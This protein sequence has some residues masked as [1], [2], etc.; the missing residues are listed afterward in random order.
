MGHVCPVCKQRR[1]GGWADRCADCILAQ[2]SPFCDVLAGWCHEQ[3]TYK[4]D[5][6]APARAPCA[7]PPD[8]Y[9]QQQKRKRE[10]DELC[11]RVAQQGL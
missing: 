4:R 11:N 5:P 1:F 6:N 3:C 7:C 2:H 9:C 10:E 8:S